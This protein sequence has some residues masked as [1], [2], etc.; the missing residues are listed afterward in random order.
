MTLHL[1]WGAALPYK[2][3]RFVAVVAF[4]YFGAFFHLGDVSPCWA[5][6]PRPLVLSVWRESSS[7]Q[8]HGDGSIIH[9]GWCVGRVVLCPLGSRGS[10][11][12]LE[13][14]SRGVPHCSE[15]LA[16]LYYLDGFEFEIVVIGGGFID[17]PFGYVWC[18]GESLEEEVRRL[19][20]TNGVLCFPGK[21]F[22]GRYILVDVWEVEFEVVQGCLSYFLPS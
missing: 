2:V 9:P 16:V 11:G 4:L 3:S 19:S 18:I 5:V 15:E 7:G 1:F 21:S 12:S 8:V 22:E 13:D 14:W 10:L 20:T 6:S 17:D